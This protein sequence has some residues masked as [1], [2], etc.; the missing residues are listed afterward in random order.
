MIIGMAFA[1]T[2]FRANGLRGGTALDFVLEELTMYVWYNS[3][4]E[5]GE[6][7]TDIP[8]LISSTGSRSRENRA[9]PTAARKICSGA[10]DVSSALRFRYQI[11][12]SQPFPNLTKIYLVQPLPRNISGDNDLRKRIITA[13]DVEITSSHFPQKRKP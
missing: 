7:L 9:K 11:C 5:Q 4:Q 13:K 6:Y 10:R 3:G 8:Q 12:Q 1:G 2:H